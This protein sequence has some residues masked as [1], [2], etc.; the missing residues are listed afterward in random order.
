MIT[1]LHLFIHLYSSIHSFIQSFIHSSDSLTLVMFLNPLSSVDVGT[2]FLSPGG[3]DVTGAATKGPEE[4]GG[5]PA[6][7]SEDVAG[8]LE[9][10]LI[11]VPRLG[12]RGQRAGGETGCPLLLHQLVL[13]LL[14]LRELS[15]NHNQTQ[16]DHEEGTHLLKT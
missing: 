6:G 10:F 3:C 16:V 13:P 2:A 7:L 12:Q 14:R 4:C 8:Q 5:A 1:S 9:E 11:T 15:R